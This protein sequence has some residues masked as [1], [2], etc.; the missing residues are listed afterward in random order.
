MVTLGGR[1]KA[2]LLAPATEWIEI[3]RES[4]TPGRLFVRYVA[5]LAAIPALARFVGSSLIGGYT[6]IVPGLIGAIGS[7]VFAL[8]LVVVTALIVDALA[9]TFDAQKNFRNAFKLA[10]YSFTPVWIAGAFLLVPGLNF[11]AI[12][13]LYGLYLLWVGLPLLLGVPREKAFPYAAVVVV[14]ALA[15]TLLLGLVQVFA[16]RR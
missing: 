8:A 14:C 16:L 9:P 11:L 1:V 3:E 7:Y 6:P 12:L 5:V 15:L 10:A 2:I 4:E 13:G